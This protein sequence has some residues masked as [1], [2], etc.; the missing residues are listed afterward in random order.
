MSFNYDS[1]S[2]RIWPVEDQEK[3]KRLEAMLVA[4]EAE[5]DALKALQIPTDF[6]HHSTMTR[7]PLPG[8][9]TPQILKRMQE[10][11]ARNQPILPLEVTPATPFGIDLAKR[12]D[13]AMQSKV[14]IHWQE[15]QRKY[16]NAKRYSCW[17][18]DCW[19]TVRPDVSRQVIW[20]N[21]MGW[22]DIEVTESALVNGN[23]GNF[24]GH[25]NKV[26]TLLITVQNWMMEHH[27][28]EWMFDL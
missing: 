20:I 5:I 17:I 3:T 26:S 16:P 21:H 1:L 7:T 27:E 2:N 13:A 12:I 8:P 18:E 22:Y 4:K 15:L 9:L 11:I 23:R 14:E 28:Y 10:E 19:Y 6:L 25:D 24:I